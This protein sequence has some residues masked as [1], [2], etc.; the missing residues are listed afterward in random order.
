MSADTSLMASIQ[1][2]IARI[3]DEQVI[4]LLAGLVRIRSVFDPE[5]PDGNERAAADYICGCLDAWGLAYQRWD[6]APQRPNF[7]VNLVGGPGPVLV[8]EGHMD[9]VTP[10]DESRW[11]RDPFA[12]EIVD[13][14]MYGRGSADMKGGVAAMMMA[15]R[16]LRDSG[17]SFP[18]TVRLAILSDEEGMMRGARSFVEEGYLDDATAAIICEPE[19]GRVCIAQKGAIRIAVDFSGV[20]SHGCMPDEGANPVAAL[21]EAIVACRNLEAAI[22]SESEPHPLLGRFSISPTVVA[23][24]I[25]DQANVI[26]ASARM[27]LDIRTGPEHDHQ[28][29]VTKIREACCSAT[30]RIDGV[31]S[32][33][34][35]VDDRPA[36]E[37]PAGAPVIAAAVAAHEQIFGE[38]P[39]VGGVPG[40][41][42]GTI[43]WMARSTPLVTWGPGD[44]TI[45][46]KANEFVRLDE[47]CD[48]ARAYA[49]AALR[50]FDIAGDSR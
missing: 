28:R 8:F 40:S 24:G 3:D 41:T 10:G 21:G 19:G 34:E 16:A 26:P 36:T 27:L 20:M 15:T 33:V 5:R 11:E 43:F 46:H 42:D 1:A 48:Y 38:T 39:P 32:V 31:S 12:A 13:G 50:F 4:E 25:P 14:V 7:V 45:P 22:L 23:G 29:I 37:T 9:V 30:A 35:V 44:T 6:V 49:V 47:V 17:Q 2:V 18:G